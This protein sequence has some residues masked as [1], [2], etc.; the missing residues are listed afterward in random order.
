MIWF[1]SRSG[2][3]LH[4]TAPKLHWS[5]MSSVISYMRMFGRMDDHEFG[6]VCKTVNA[7][8]QAKMAIFEILRYRLIGY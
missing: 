7:F 2:V 6:L 8:K 3:A 4:E 5:M 1:V